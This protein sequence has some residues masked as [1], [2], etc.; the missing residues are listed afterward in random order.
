MRCY[1]VS[2]CSNWFGTFDCSSETLPKHI[3][4]WTLLTQQVKQQ[5]SS[6]FHL[7]FPPF[8]FPKSLWE[9]KK[10][11]RELS[12]VNS[13]PSRILLVDLAFCLYLR[14]FNLWTKL[15]CPSLGKLFL[16]PKYLFTF[17]IMTSNLLFCPQSTRW[18]EWCLYSNVHKKAAIM[19]VLAWILFEKKMSWHGCSEWSSRSTYFLQHYQTR[20]FFLFLF[21]GPSL[22]N[23]CLLIS[24]M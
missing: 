5:L 24:A 14:V 21:H 9:L 10:N 16:S 4:M 23:P 22:W 20:I 11:S 15:Q 6:H 18:A 19:H 7:F 8:S 12:A 3:L 2:V 13:L 17:C 1:A